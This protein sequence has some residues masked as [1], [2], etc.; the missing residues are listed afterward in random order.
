MRL[1]AL[2][3]RNRLPS[4]YTATR[5]AAVCTCWPGAHFF[6]GVDSSSDLACRQ[7][8]ALIGS[9]VHGCV[10]CWRPLLT[11]HV[12]GDR[13]T[14]GKHYGIV[15]WMFGPFRLVRVTRVAVVGR[16]GSYGRVVCQ[17]DTEEDWNAKACSFLYV[18]VF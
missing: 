17:V 2:Q 7:A 1:E 9:S 11:P 8:D 3:K 14:E 6:L 18:G 10:L 16:Y 5:G 12:W 15:R 13:Q 4:C